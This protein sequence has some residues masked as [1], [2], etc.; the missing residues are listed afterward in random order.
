MNFPDERRRRLLQGAGA[1]ALGAV[2]TGPGFAAA[3]AAEGNAKKV[4]RILFNSAETSL[5]PA[6]VSDL[7]SRTLTAHI[8]ES[9]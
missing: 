6:R 5:D 7:Y 4:L 9:L 8:F 3:P 1:M 2:G